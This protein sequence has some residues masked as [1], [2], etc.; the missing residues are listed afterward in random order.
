MAGAPRCGGRRD[1]AYF[2]ISMFYNGRQRFTS[3]AESGRP[4]LTFSAS[5]ACWLPF[6]LDRSQQNSYLVGVVVGSAEAKPAEARL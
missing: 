5:L 6:M 2:H 1:E 3:A 4:E